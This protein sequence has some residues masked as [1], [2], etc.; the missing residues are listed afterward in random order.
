M[1]G[2]DTELEAADVTGRRGRSSPSWKS[3]AGGGNH[4]D[5]DTTP[6]LE[7]FV[8]QRTVLLTSFRGDGTPVGTP[9]TIAVEGDHAFIRSFDAAWKVKRMRRNPEVEVAPSTFKG[10]AARTGHP[11]MGASARG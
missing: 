11:G 10:C 6:V 1:T 5:D 7:P 9:V 3:I 4:G 8:E 2:A